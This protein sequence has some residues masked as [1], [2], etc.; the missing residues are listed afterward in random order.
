[1]IVG[2]N[3]CA[4]Q[5]CTTFMNCASINN[6][7]SGC[8]VRVG[9]NKVLE[10]SVSKIG[11]F[12]STVTQS[13]TTINTPKAM[14]LN[15]TD[16]FSSGISIVSNSQITVDTAGIY[17]L[18][19]SAQVDRLTTSGVDL[20]EIWF[21]KQG[22]DIPNSTTK[23][24]VSGSANQ[25]KLVASWNIYLSLTAGQ[26][27]ELMFSVTDLQVKLVTEAENLVVPYPAT[28]SLIVTMQKIN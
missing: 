22:V 25:A 2:S 16:A 20:I 10:N 17:N 11:S 9:T 8:I 21:R 24:T 23:V 12:F 5:A 6:L 7:T 3:L 18:Q 19:F 27:V 26:Y 28:P 4:T 15:N 1:M 13:A 14:T